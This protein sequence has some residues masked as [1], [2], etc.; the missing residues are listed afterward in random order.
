MS[1][2]SPHAQSYFVQRAGRSFFAFLLDLAAFLLST[3]LA[4]EL[5][6]DGALPAQYVH[7]MGVAL[8]I[9]A[10]VK[11]ACFLAGAVGRG[12]WRHASYHDAVRIVLANSVGSIL[13]GILLFRLI[14]PS[15]IPR[16]VYILDWLLSCLLTLGGRLAVRLVVAL[17]SRS[18]A[19]GE[20]IRTL[21][22]G[23]GSAGLALLWELRQNHALMS[24]VIGIVDDDP[25][26]VGL[27]LNGKRV[28]GTGEDLEALV[29]KHAIKRVLI[30]IPS[31]TGPQ[32]VR[33]LKL[34]IDAKAEYRM[35]PGLGELI[36]GTEL[37]KQIREVAVEDLLG[38]KPVHL[39]LDRIRARIEGRVVMVT[40][41]AGSI[42]SEIC[43]QIAPFRPLAIVGFDEAET[44][45]F[46]ID[47]EMARRFPSVAFHAEIGSINRRD[48][49]KRVMQRYKPSIL[50]HAAAYKHVPLMET[51]V[52][53]AVETN[54]LGTW[55][56]GR[57]AIEYGVDDFVMIST[58]KAVRP[59]SMMGA[60]KRV[61]ELLIRALQLE[62]G[63]KFV[64]VRFGNVLGSNGSVI[65]IFKEQIAA[66]GPVTVTHPEICRYFMTIPEAAQLVLQAFSIGQGGEVFVLEMG[67]PVKI[68]DLARNL[69]LLSGLQPER[70]IE[71]QYTG[72]RP[73]EKM[74]E[75]LNLRDENLIPTSHAKIRS[76][77][78][79]QKLD[80]MQIKAS[81]HRLQAIA[82]EQDVANLVLL[83]KEL[84]PDYNPCS[85]LLKTALSTKTSH[86]VR[87]QVAVLT[88][89]S[90]TPAAAKLTPATLVN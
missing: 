3:F 42:G 44:P 12:S 68:A 24:D 46:Y 30:A 21:I 48:T 49:L 9:W 2:K 39:D 74:Y 87:A 54:I 34:A 10:A 61:A 89:Q 64:A 36:Q 1:P 83:L 47:R 6:F 15:G 45:L 7:P 65:P 75:E 70:D 80:A 13:G 28:M 78:C 82:E 84:I 5:R 81:L 32:M 11:S 58:D 20:R 40:G 14:G 33:I 35:V 50:Y 69:I 22:Y 90:E 27:V 62:G 29:Q 31:A 51:H 19:A 57:V 66:G 85:Q 53:A 63:T 38:R 60:T 71:I 25:S 76:Y 8:C 26:K 18:R 67:D 23:A 17:K 59:T 72:L 4:F 77:V 86:E 16:S 55:N 79:Q 52:F 88:V 73:G 56:V 37:G 41:A 43:R